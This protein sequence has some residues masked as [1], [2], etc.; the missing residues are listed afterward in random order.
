MEAAA[1][2]VVASTE[3][4]ELAA[5]YGKTAQRGKPY[6][7]LHLTEPPIVEMMRR[8]GVRELRSRDS[9]PPPILAVARR[10][11][12]LAIVAPGAVRNE[13]NSFLVLSRKSA[14]AL[15]LQELALVDLACEG[16]GSAVRRHELS[17]R[18]AHDAALLEAAYAVSRSI[19]R[20]LDLDHT[21]Q[22]VARSASHLVIGARCIVFEKSAHAD[23]IT[24]V[25]A[26]PDSIARQLGGAE[27]SV[28]EAVLRDTAAGS[29]VALN[30]L[31]VIAGAAVEP[32]LRRLLNARSALLMPLTAHGEPIGALILYSSARRSGF[33]EEETARVTDLAEQAST[34]ISNARLF[35]DLAE[36]Q[37][38]IEALL[39]RMARIREQER[40]ALATLVHDDLVQTIVAASFRMEAL[41]KHVSDAGLPLFSGTLDALRESIKDARR[42]IWE[43]RPPVLDELT[44]CESLQS[45]ASGIEADG[46]PRVTVIVKDDRPLSRDCATAVYK[47]AREAILNAHRHAAAS[48]VSVVLDVVR[49]DGDAYV[50]LLVKDNGVGFG[51]A[52][53]QSANHYG[54]VFMEE[55][56][57]AVGG[58]LSVGSREGS[59]TRVLAHLP[60]RDGDHGGEEYA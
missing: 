12:G 46:G 54:R 5:A 57:A 58:N 60:I 48:A 1:V 23:S 37:K 22:Q 11:F 15:T 51:A 13:V 43:L 28:D 17:S 45:L 52:S 7:P 30:V 55:Q 9:V 59:G 50:V 19:S 18:S 32:R 6:Q 38:R 4:A 56:A 34:A 39:A 25:G 33:T 47:I 2:F 40:Q 8:P 36:S 3:T 21:I 27:L 35:R 26:Y 31:D 20:T 42:V 44:L 10:P 41:R 49:R 29:A 14:D 53:E 24:L 16:L